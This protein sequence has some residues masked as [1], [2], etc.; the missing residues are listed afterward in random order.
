[1]TISGLSSRLPTARTTSLAFAG[2]QESAARGVEGV[3]DGGVGVDRDHRAAC[4]VRSRRKRLQPAEDVV[5][6][7]EPVEVAE[8]LRGEEIEGARG[9]RHGRHRLGDACA[10]ALRVG[11]RRR[12][13]RSRAISRSAAPTDR[14]CSRRRSSRPGSCTS[15][16]SGETDGHF[17]VGEAAVVRHV[18]GGLAL[19]RVLGHVVERLGRDRLRALAELERNV[20]RC[21]SLGA[22]MRRPQRRDR[23]PVDDEVV[24]HLQVAE[25]DRQLLA[26]GGMDLE[27]VAVGAAR[28]VAEV[29]RVGLGRLRGLEAARSPVRPAR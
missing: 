26:G 9:R 1:M 8:A 7:L 23:R 24:V 16:P 27:V 20:T 18:E 22:G 3:Q 15:R 14:C 12:Q 11:A 6:G 10:G 28:R 5:L 13:R 25:V 17:L 29:E 19:T 4:R 21:G 2:E